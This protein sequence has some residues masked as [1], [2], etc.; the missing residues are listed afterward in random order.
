MN[1]RPRHAIVQLLFRD[2]LE[3]LRGI[4]RVFFRSGGGSHGPIAESSL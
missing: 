2:M 1:A 3:V 4:K